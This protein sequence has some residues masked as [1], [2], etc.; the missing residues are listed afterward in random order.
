MQFILLNPQERKW[1]SFF[2]DAAWNS[3][4]EQLDSTLLLGSVLSQCST[5]VGDRVEMPSFACARMH[6]VRREEGRGIQV[7]YLN[8]SETTSMRPRKQK[9]PELQYEI[10]VNSKYVIP[11]HP[12]QVFCFLSEGH[13][14]NQESLFMRNLKDMTSFSREW[15]ILNIFSI[16]FNISRDSQPMS[17][18]VIWFWGEVH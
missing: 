16:L 11:K 15:S 1:R 6:R 4:C 18:S 7:S 12:N 9:S 2:K 5:V 3:I 14:N 8:N 10:V 13:Q 17:P